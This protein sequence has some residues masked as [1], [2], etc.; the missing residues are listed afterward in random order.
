MLRFNLTDL[1][2]VDDDLDLGVSQGGHSLQEFQGG[3]QTLPQL[4][5]GLAPKGFA[6]EAGGCREGDRGERVLP[7]IIELVDAKR[8]LKCRRAKM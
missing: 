6:A 7:I 3:H 4:Y 5:D 8:S 2:N 1:D